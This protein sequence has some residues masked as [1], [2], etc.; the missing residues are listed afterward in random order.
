MNSSRCA[1]I[2][3]MENIWTINSSLCRSGSWKIFK[4]REV[5][6]SKPEKISSY[7]LTTRFGVSFRPSTPGPR[8]P[9]V[10]LGY[11]QA[12]SVPI[13]A[14]PSVIDKAVQWSLPFDFCPAHSVP[15]PSIKGFLS[16]AE[17]GVGAIVHNMR[18]YRFLCQGGRRDIKIQIQG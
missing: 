4:W 12:Q 11:R 5:V 16:F 13:H 8:P 2:R 18:I 6:V 3:N 17:I 9:P 15:P 14:V 1:R 10:N 7:I